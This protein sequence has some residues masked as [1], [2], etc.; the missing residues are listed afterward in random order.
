MTVED[1]YLLPRLPCARVSAPCHCTCCRSPW[2]FP[3]NTCSVCLNNGINSKAPINL[4]KD[5]AE[6][7]A[8]RDLVLKLG[9]EGQP[10]TP[11]M[12]CFLVYKVQRSF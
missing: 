10:I 4:P 5:P 7:P 9:W 2:Y 3:G 12:F 1:N 6:K 8:S 11:Q